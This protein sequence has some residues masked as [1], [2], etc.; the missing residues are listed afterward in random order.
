MRMTSSRS[1]I[2][3]HMFSPFVPGGVQT[4]ATV[5]TKLHVQNMQGRLRDV[6][7]KSDRVPGIVIV[8]QRGH[9]SLTKK[10]P[11]RKSS[12]SLPEASAQPLH[13]AEVGLARRQNTL[14]TLPKG[15]A[16]NNC[17]ALIGQ[18]GD[19]QRQ[20]KAER[21]RERETEGERNKR[22]LKRMY[23]CTLSGM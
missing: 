14:N 16:P 1:S 21:E 8:R 4:R 20:R 5:T 11:S 2:G 22:G 17:P 19:E 15:A 12:W 3:P 13:Q 7:S 9:C 23:A 18:L 6:H 10:K